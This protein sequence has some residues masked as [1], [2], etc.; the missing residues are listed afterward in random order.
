MEEDASGG[1][2]E[3]GGRGR[4]GGVREVVRGGGEAGDMGMESE[5]FC[6]LYRGE[7]VEEGV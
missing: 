3:E 1:V 5:L 4:G 7:V 6:R 2:E